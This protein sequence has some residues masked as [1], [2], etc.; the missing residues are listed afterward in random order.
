MERAGQGLRR[1]AWA[2]GAIGSLL[3]VGPVVVFGTGY[4]GAK[5][6]GSAMEPTYSIGDRVLLERIDAGEVRR[7]DVVLYRAPERY[8]GLAVL[9]RVIGVGG[10]QVAQQPGGPVTLNGSPLTEPYVKDGDPSGVPSGY[11]VVVPQGR[12]FVLGDFRA[13]ARDSRFF[14]DDRSGTVGSTTVL[15]RALHDRSGL[16]GLGLAMLLGLLLGV[17]ALVSGIAARGARKRSLPTGVP[18]PPH[19]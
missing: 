17:T 11:D 16:A 4:T 7:G 14:L 12:L 3:L 18:V 19:A 9:G 10:D 13:N 15:G 1:T 5:V 2:A 8:E 6:S